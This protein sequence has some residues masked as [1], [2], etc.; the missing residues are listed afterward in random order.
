MHW[1]VAPG[2]FPVGASVHFRT[3][4]SRIRTLRQS[5]YFAN[6]RK[7]TFIAKEQSGCEGATLSWFGVENCRTVA[8][9]SV[10]VVA[11]KLDSI[12]ALRYE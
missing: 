12:V 1:D 6:Q 9:R 3:P 8:Y 7:S 10:R 5:D 11:A 2:Q 4:H